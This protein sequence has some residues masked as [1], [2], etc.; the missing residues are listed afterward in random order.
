M[1]PL[2]P[3]LNRFISQLGWKTLA[4]VGTR[5]IG[6]LFFI[7]IARQLGDQ[8]YGRYSYPLALAALW[9]VL[10]DWGQNAL[11]IRDLGRQDFARRPFL[12]RVL[13]LKLA[14]ST[15]FFSCFLLTCW[16]S[17]HSL[18]THWLIAA[19]LFVLGQAW[20]DT[21]AAG[22]NS[23]HLFRIE[24]RLKILQRL[25][26]LLPQA[27]VLIF[28]PQISLL[29]WAAACGQIATVLLS[30]YLARKALSTASDLPQT[31]ALPTPSYRYLVQ[32]GL[33]FWLANIAWL[34]YL[35][36]DLVMLPSL[37]RP[38]VELGWYQAA[39]RC[40]EIFALAGY[41]VSAALFP[42]IAAKFK[43][44]PPKSALLARRWLQLAGVAASLGLL[45]WLLAP[46]VLVWT[47][48]QEYLA[49]GQSLAILSLSIPFV[50]M[51]QIGF[52]LLAALNRQHRVAISTGL[53][54]AFNI[55]L[56]S[57]WIPQF[58]LFGA[59]WSTVLADLL[60]WLMISYFLL[61]KN[62]PNLSARH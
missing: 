22:L 2:S 25:L 30:W 40:Y 10:L 29:L 11:M 28:K 36:I 4:E 56:N 47:L 37:G 12:Q 13:V 46:K 27:A 38:L 34:L 1:K 44:S 3:L 32:A 20:L 21:L 54:L 14:A 7:W 52:N 50:F 35:K 55:C 43:Q 33:S 8:Q 59:A 51:N 26:L 41:L 5:L 39:I 57:F 45:A 60:L 15:L 23:Q 31:S 62:K 6:L 48:G 9:A 42:L 18:P 24:A 17:G 19:A 61:Q 53:C 16:L 58:G 49:A